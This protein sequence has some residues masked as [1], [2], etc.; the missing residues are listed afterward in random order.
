M[1]KNLKQII[2]DYYHEMVNT[3]ETGEEL[4]SKIKTKNKSLIQKIID[5]FMDKFNF[6]NTDQQNND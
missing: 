1:A 3:T 2:K 5:H 4:E 6:L